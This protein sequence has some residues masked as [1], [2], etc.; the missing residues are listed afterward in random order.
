MVLFAGTPIPYT[1]WVVTFFNLGIHVPGM[2]DI[3]APG[4][5]LSPDDEKLYNFMK[6]N[7]IAMPFLWNIW[8][9]W[10]LCLAWMKIIAVWTGAVP[11]IIIGCVQCFASLAV[12]IKQEP[13]FQEHANATVKPFMVSATGFGSP[14]LPTCVQLSVRTQSSMSGYGR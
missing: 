11:F 9:L 8:G 13:V 5:A 12:M 3:F 10:A 7:P 1:K 14:P 2:R 4:K 6:T